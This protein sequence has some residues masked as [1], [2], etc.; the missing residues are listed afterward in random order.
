MSLPKAST[1]CPTP[2]KYLDT[3][4][5]SSVLSTLVPA[6]PWSCQ[7]MSSCQRSSSI[8]RAWASKSRRDSTR[9]SVSNTMLRTA[10]SQ[11]ERKGGETL[12]CQTVSYSCIK[13][14]LLPLEAE[15]T[16]FSLHK[17]KKPYSKLYYK[18]LW[19]TFQVLHRTRMV[20]KRNQI[21][22]HIFYCTVIRFH[23]S[24]II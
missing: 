9:R 10:K 13:P 5:W 19:R 20:G 15:V 22:T 3:R 21:R 17:T 11:A 7:R 18:K 16:L 6:A 23:L 4:F 12:I 8:S 24:Q 14:L 1:S 2:E